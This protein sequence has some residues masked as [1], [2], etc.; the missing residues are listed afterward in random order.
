MTEEGVP[1]VPDTPPQSDAAPLIDE[2]VALWAAR[3]VV[4]GRREDPE[5]AARLRT[6][7]AADLPRIDAAARRWT[8]LGTDL[9]PTEVRVVGRVG[10]VRANLESMRGAFD[11]LRE[12]LGASRRVVASRVLGAQLGAL[13]G[14]LSMKVLGQ[15]VLPL[16]GPGGGQLLVVGPNVLELGR[17]RGELA[18]DVRRTVLLHEVTHRLQFDAT[19]WLG[20]HLRGIVDRYLGAARV[21]TAALAEVAA[22]LPGAVAEVVTS[23]DVQPLLRVVLTPEQRDVID[24]A[25]GLM[26][27]LEGHGNA[28][29]HGATEGVI[30]D[31]DGV[32]DHLASRRN[33]LVSRVLTAVAGLEMK[34]RQYREGEAFV[35][36]VIA[37]A[38]VA[39][40]NRAFEDPDH[41]PRGGE[42][43]DPDGWLA[44]VSADADGD[45]GR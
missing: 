4:P 33:D 43:A 23:G 10:W 35:D 19:P 40:L 28:A 25:Q 18:A 45:A 31:P 8:E 41:L 22:D 34:R 37:R 42:V 29:M 20:D 30:D 21:D 13:L 9:S 16:G 36:G 38:G 24:E 12:R 7:V 14:L 27:L 39:G 5:S 26:S 3:L 1:H 11:P 32:R 15:Y 6:E 44:R 2:R 17:E